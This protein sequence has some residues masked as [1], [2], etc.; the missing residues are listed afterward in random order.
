M[1][2]VFDGISQSVDLGTAVNFSGAND[3][4]SVTAWFNA[5]TI[6]DSRVIDKSVGLNANDITLMLGITTVGGQ[7]VRGNLDGI[8]VTSVE[9][10][11]TGQ[12][13]FLAIVYNGATV[14]LYLDGVEVDSTAHT[15]NVAS[16]AR[17]TRIAS[18]GHDTTAREFDGKIA[19]V[20]VY[21]RAL[22]VNELLTMF[23]NRG[24]DMIP[25][26]YR[27]PLNDDAPGVVIG[28]GAVQNI[29]EIAGSDG[30]GTNTPDFDTHDLS[31]RRL[32]T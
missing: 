5:A 23:A 8:A 2:G 29:G 31:L 17:N 24:H 25:A 3:A 14:K 7:S 4:G 19:D 22:S 6:A 9:T 12:W 11:N 10:V 1:S 20:R 27:W 16:D 30:G 28:A 32:I 15:G 26:R 21:D 13:Y 18:A